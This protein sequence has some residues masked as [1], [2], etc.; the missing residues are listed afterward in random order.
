M[1]D[2]GENREISLP[3]KL[4]LFFFH[5]TISI[6]GLIFILISGLLII[7]FLSQIDFSRFYIDEKSPKAKAIITNIIPTSIKEGSQ[8]IYKYNFYYQ[9]DQSK[10][11]YSLSSYGINPHS[12]FASSNE[13]NL[14]PGDTVNV[15]YSEIHPEIAKIEG[16]DYKPAPFFLLII[17]LIPLMVG[18]ILLLIQVPD[19]LK[20][21]RLV[22]QGIKG[23]ALFISMNRTNV[24]INGR[25]VMKLLFR[26]KT[27][28]GEHEFYYKT[29]HPEPYRT[30][31]IKFPIL[32]DPDKS[33]HAILIQE[34]PGKIRKLINE[35]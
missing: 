17:M 29:N 28:T 13:L 19:Y 23:E 8:R 30:T 18:L 35:S 16:M 11:T 7:L 24:K 1:I 33:G 10:T 32:Y 21:L 6:V 14:K 20:T 15:I 3:L 34:L 2:L 9:P 5:K 4:Q 25:R 27:K 22:R 12:P 26:Y 31:Q